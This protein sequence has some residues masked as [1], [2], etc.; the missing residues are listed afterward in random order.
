MS[1][2]RI[3]VSRATSLGDHDM[4]RPIGPSSADLPQSR[5]YSDFGRRQIVGR[6]EIPQRGLQSRSHLRGTHGFAAKRLRCGKQARREQRCICKAQIVKRPQRDGRS[7]GPGAPEEER[8]AMGKVHIHRS[9]HTGTTPHKHASDTR[10]T[11]PTLMT[12]TPTVPIKAERARHVGP[13][14]F[15]WLFM[16]RPALSAGLS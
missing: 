16:Q 3:G 10:S 6:R 15:S 13:S 11:E 5:G 4:Q 14:P 8:R 12:K 9:H 7:D 1:R 2:N